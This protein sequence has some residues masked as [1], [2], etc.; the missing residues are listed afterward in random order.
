M[1]ES[2]RRGE[3]RG[4]ARRAS[5]QAVND[6]KTGDKEEESEREGGQTYRFSINIYRGQSVAHAQQKTKE[7][8]EEERKKEK[9]KKE[10]RKKRKERRRRGNSVFFCCSSIFFFLSSCSIFRLC[11]FAFELL[12]LLMR[13]RRR[14]QRQRR[15]QL[16]ALPLPLPP[17]LRFVLPFSVHLCDATHSRMHNQQL[18]CKCV[19]VCV[20]VSVCMCVLAC[21][22]SASASAAAAALPAL[23]V[24]NRGFFII[25]WLRAAFMVSFLLLLSLMLLLLFFLSPIL[26]FCNFCFCQFPFRNATA[27][28]LCCC[29]YLRSLPRPIQFRLIRFWFCRS[30]SLRL[31]F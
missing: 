9:R 12:L 11:C 18:K 20:W 24:C 25:I 8:E 15:R 4:P 7:E 30:L 10:R 17:S 2:G 28:C 1:W 13:L 14:Q 16:L 5:T 23:S 21:S 19:R 27:N 22:V 29:C 26:V 6:I 31:V 3:G